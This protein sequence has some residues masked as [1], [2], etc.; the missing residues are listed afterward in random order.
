MPP[1]NERFGLVFAKTGSINSGTGRS[2][3]GSVHSGHS[4]LKNHSYI[5][6][7]TVCRKEGLTE[8]KT[9]NFQGVRIL[10][11]CIRD[12]LCQKITCTYVLYV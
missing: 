3:L 10:D 4:S 1:E 5:C 6:T 11:R 9:T 7:S 12:T 8:R 2:N